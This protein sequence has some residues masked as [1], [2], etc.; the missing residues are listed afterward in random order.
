[1]V[2]RIGAGSITSTTKDNRAERARPGAR[3]HA[4]G[5]AAASHVRY[6]PAVTVRDL[7]IQ[8][9]SKAAQPRVR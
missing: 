3:L 9:P 8:G 6:S 7:L 4:T 5:S 1:M 2:W